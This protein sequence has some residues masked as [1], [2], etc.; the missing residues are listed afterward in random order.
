VADCVD[1]AVKEIQTAVAQAVL[2]RPAAKAQCEELALGN[3][4]VLTARQ[5]GQF[6]LPSTDFDTPGMPFSVDVGHGGDHG[7]RK[8]SR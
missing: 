4:A 3:N 5:L 7:R 2:D 8:L 1:A 6:P